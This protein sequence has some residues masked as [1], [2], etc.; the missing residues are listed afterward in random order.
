LQ[1]NPDCLKRKQEWQVLREKLEQESQKTFSETKDTHAPGNSGTPEQ[2]GAEL[3]MGF[4]GV[5]P[6]QLH[7]AGFWFRFLA[8]VIDSLIFVLAGVIFGFILGAMGG[9]AKSLDIPFFIASW[10]YCASLSRI[11][12]AIG[13]HLE[14]QR[15]DILLRL[16]R[17]SH[18]KHWLYRGSLYS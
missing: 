10:L 7:Y 9:S 14:G 16:F 18:I 3:D 12:P 15:E 17:V 11:F 4:F 1:N 5:L 6:Q 8:L 2:A 13:Y